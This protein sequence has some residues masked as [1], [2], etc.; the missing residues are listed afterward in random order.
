MRQA[1]AHE[2]RSFPAPTPISSSHRAARL[3]FRS[4]HDRR[5]AHAPSFLDHHAQPLAAGGSDWL[6]SQS[7]AKECWARAPAVQRGLFV[8][9]SA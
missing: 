4:S 9:R 8:Q 3:P 7:R 5:A 2:S 1:S 6:R